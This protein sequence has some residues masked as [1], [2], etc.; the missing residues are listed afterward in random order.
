MESNLVRAIHSPLL[1]DL[2][3]DSCVVSGYGAIRL[4]GGV[5]GGRAA[6]A[7]SIMRDIAMQ[8]M[9]AGPSV[10]EEKRL[11]RKECVR[12]WA[13][14]LM[15]HSDGESLLGEMVEILRE[16]SRGGDE[17]AAGCLSFLGIPE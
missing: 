9:W 8:G 7:A 17:Q 12:A 2:G 6:V 1:M 10:R 15:D 11:E 13:E 3:N 14:L 4:S 16:R 5:A